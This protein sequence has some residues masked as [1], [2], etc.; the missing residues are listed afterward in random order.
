[1]SAALQAVDIVE[2][3][4]GFVVAVRVKVFFCDHQFFGSEFGNA[5]QLHAE[6]RLL[7]EIVV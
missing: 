7:N 6:K 5:L 4:F 3:H 1:M 2:R